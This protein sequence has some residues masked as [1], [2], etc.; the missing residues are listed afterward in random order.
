[1]LP[2]RPWSEAGRRA[3]RCDPS[4][5]TQSEPV[6]HERGAPTRSIAKS[7]FCIWAAGVERSESPV[8]RHILGTASTPTPGTHRLCNRPGVPKCKD[9]RRRKPAVRE[10][11][12]P[13]SRASRRALPRSGHHMTPP[14]ARHCRL[15]PSSTTPRVTP[16][17]RRRARRS[18]TQ[19]DT[20]ALAA[21]YKQPNA[22]GDGTI[23]PVP[24]IA[25]ALPHRVR[26]RDGSVL[27]L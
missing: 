21:Q 5:L 4:I 17:P 27:T 2:W 1:M 18:C 3:L 16:S 11:Y 20:K 8:L 12:F 24:T 25:A 13:V 10:D 7:I 26:P 15:S 6:R 19:A 9:D 22:P 14:T 23:I